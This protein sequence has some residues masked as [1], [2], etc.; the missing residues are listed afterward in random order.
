[1]LNSKGRRREEG[2]LRTGHTWSGSRPEE[3]DAKEIVEVDEELVEATVNVLCLL[4]TGQI[5]RDRHLKKG[6]QVTTHNP[7]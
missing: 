4:V 6:R 5:E 2:C 7:N 3:N 1:M